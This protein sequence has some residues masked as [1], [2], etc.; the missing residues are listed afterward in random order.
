MSTTHQISIEDYLATAYR[1]DRDYVDG[2][3]EERNVGEKEH[4]IV[5]AFFVKWFAVFERDW[6]LEAFPEI[7]IRVTPNRVR[8]ADVAVERVGIPYEAVLEKPPI[9][10]VEILS[11]QDRV[12][13]YQERLED[14][15]RMGIQQVWVIDPMRRKAYDCSAI[16]WQPVDNFMIAGTPVRVELAKLWQKLAEMH[17]PR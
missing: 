10:V 9:A 8:I 12:S 14:Y 17:S 15:R 1:P 13:R 5:Q 3:V 7:R 11:P 16:D 4:S 6:R 2:E